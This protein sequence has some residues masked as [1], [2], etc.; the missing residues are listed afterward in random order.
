MKQLTI[1]HLYF[2]LLSFNSFSFMRN[3]AGGSIYTPS[4]IKCPNS[5]LTLSFATVEAG[6][7]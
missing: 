7:V 2:I 3:V 1:I 4:K 5:R 6:E